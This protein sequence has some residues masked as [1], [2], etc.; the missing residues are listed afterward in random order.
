MSFLKC[1][2]NTSTHF[3]TFSV[4]GQLLEVLSDPTFRGLMENE[5]LVSLLEIILR[6]YISQEE[7]VYHLLY[8]FISILFYILMES[9]APVPFQDQPAFSQF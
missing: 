4:S 2:N 3:R 8:K 5:E 1:Y 6:S 9:L 7:S